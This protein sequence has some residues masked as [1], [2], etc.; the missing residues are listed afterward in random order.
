MA[1]W[2]FVLAQADGTTLC[3]LPTATGKK[4]SFQR[5]APAEVEFSIS[6]ADD[7][8]YTLL[9]HLTRGWPTLRCY[10]DGVLRFN[11]YLAPFTEELEESAM[12]HLRFRSPFGKLLGDGENRGRF[13]GEF[14]DYVADAGAIALALIDIANTDEL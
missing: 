3:E 1:S 5:N 6:H 12:L 2:V 13:T 4:L 14:V 9:D 10:R 7:A 8:A 11:G